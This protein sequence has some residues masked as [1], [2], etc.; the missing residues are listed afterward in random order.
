MVF[1]T[2]SRSRCSEPACNH[3]GERPE[4]MS[5][6]RQETRPRPQ[7]SAPGHGNR[8]LPGRPGI[9]RPHRRAH[10]KYPGARSRHTC[11]PDIGPR[12]TTPVATG[13]GAGEIRNT[14]RAGRPGDWAKARNRFSRLDPTRRRP[15]RSSLV[16]QRRPSAVFVYGHAIARPG[17]RKPRPRS[18]ASQAPP[19]RKNRDRGA[20]PDAAWPEP[21]Q[22]SYEELVVSARIRHRLAKRNIGVERCAHESRDRVR[23]ARDA[24]RSGVGQNRGGDSP[25]GS[26]REFGRR[27]SGG[28]RRP[29]S[30]RRGEARDSGFSDRRAG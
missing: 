3:R 7:T 8:L 1:K 30:R 11:Q 26:P 19:G 14:N 16:E 10:Q 25:P 29:S 21:A 18:A 5:R 2:S 23:S 17:G 4:G 6:L 28:A 27:L 9:G 12:E 20:G 22:K 24:R 13:A 15:N